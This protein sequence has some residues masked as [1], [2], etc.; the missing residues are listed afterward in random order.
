ME[1]T[2]RRATLADAALLVEIYDAAFFDDFVRYGEC[3]RVWSDAGADGAVHCAGTEIRDLLW[4]GRGR[5]HFLGKP[6]AGAVFSGLPLR[7]PRVAGKGHWNTG[8]SVFP[9]CL[10]GLAAD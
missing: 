5:R 8:F 1:V 10:S 2:F 4:F 9:P 6:R 7:A 3:P